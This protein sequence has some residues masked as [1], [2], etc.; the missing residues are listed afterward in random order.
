MTL[1]WKPWFCVL[2]RNDPVIKSLSCNVFNMAD[3]LQLRPVG[4]CYNVIRL[5]YCT[6]SILC[7][8]IYIYVYI[9]IERHRCHVTVWFSDFGDEWII[10]DHPNFVKPFGSMF[11]ERNG[12][13]MTLILFI[14][15]ILTSARNLHALFMYY[16]YFIEERNSLDKKSNILYGIE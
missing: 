14:C 3:Y 11:S 5:R 2:K 1:S 7:L 6:V 10:H 16:I 9:C 4:G 13:L 15:Y 12:L 8:R